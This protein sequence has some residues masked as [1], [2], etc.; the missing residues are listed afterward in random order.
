MVIGVRLTVKADFVEGFMID[1]YII[2]PSYNTRR[3]S[4]QIY[5]Q[6]YYVELSARSSP[7]SGKIR[8]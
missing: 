1:F 3:N 7:L 6:I 2:D 5:G 8:S 4:I